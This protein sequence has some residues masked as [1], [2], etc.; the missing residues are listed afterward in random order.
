MVAGRQVFEER[1]CL[2]TR[3]DLLN[4]AI[5][6]NFDLIVIGGGA[7]GAG[8][9][10]DAAVRG[11]S[12]LLLEQH[13]FGKGTSSRSTK[14]VHGGVRYLAQGNIRLVREALYERSLLLKN[15]PHLCHVQPFVVPLYRWW[16]APFY[17]TGLLLYDLLA[18]ADGI[19]NARYLNRRDVIKRLPTIQRHGLKGGFLYYDGQFDDA[20]LLIDLL[21]TAVECGAV[22]L[23]YAKVEKLIRHSDRVNGVVWREMETGTENETSARIVINATGA[24]CDQV[25]TMIDP[26]VQPLV[27]PSQGSHLVF[28]RPFLPGDHAIMVPKTRDGRVMFAI[29]WHGHTLVGTTDVAIRRADLEPRT[30]ESEIELILETAGRYLARPPTRQDVRS[31]FAGIRPLVK[32]SNT[33]NT[34]KLSRDHTIIEEAGLLTI[35]GGKWTTYRNMAEDCLDHAAA[36]AGLPARVCR[37]KTLVI[38]GTPDQ[39]DVVRSVRY[40]FARTVEDVLARRRRDL[41]LNPAN[42]R[43]LAPHIAKL[44]AKELARD[45]A[46]QKEQVHAFAELSRRYE[47]TPS[48]SGDPAA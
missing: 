20:R 4:R 41:F 40:E 6:T 45:E 11:Y 16:E 22:A 14:L 9:A 34:A 36:V 24:F 3:E 17:G 48:T 26:N 32:T 7:T 12:V 37:T 10:I 1:G 2:V 25:R 8:I 13:D 43:Q 47:M 44:M 31:V 33:R 42:A 18:G 23:N 39:P 5:G 38:R 15:A 19:G 21:R 30:T 27:S 35:T 29:P 46:W 28:D